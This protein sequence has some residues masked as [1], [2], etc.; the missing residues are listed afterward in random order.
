MEFSK[1]E[2]HLISE[3]LHRLLSMHISSDYEIEELCDRID[4]YL[5]PSENE[6]D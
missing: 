6:E 2:L 5:F 3:S 1:N 4:N